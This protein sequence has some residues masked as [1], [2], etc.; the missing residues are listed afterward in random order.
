[1]SIFWD[2]NPVH[3]GAAIIVGDRITTVGGVLP[4]SSRSDL[5]S[6]FGTR[7]RAAA[8]LAE[9][10][11]AM[12][13]VVSEERGEVSVA[14][15]DQVERVAGWERLAELLEDHLMGLD[16]H[17]HPQRSGRREFRFAAL[18]SLVTVAIV[19]FI[20]TRSGDTLMG[21]DVPLEFTNRNQAYRYYR[22]FSIN[23]SSA[24]ERFRYAAEIGAA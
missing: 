18:A 19:W 16:E 22:R 5:P 21:I 1:M 3:D 2:D 9:Q 14:K 4:L 11:D 12:V 7:H 23:R 8:G 17:R 10:T 6:F 24:A 15:G 20:F 13:V